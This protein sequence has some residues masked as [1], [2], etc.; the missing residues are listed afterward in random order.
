MNLKGSLPLLILHILSAG[1]SHGYHI[2]KQIRE[3]SDG[4]LD[5]KEGT[6][7]PTLHNL[8]DRGLIAGFDDVIDGRRRRYYQLT[9]VGTA[10]L[11]SERAEW[12]NFVCYVNKI[13]NEKPDPA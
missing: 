10:G 2:S 6:L 4:V 9:D 7:Y 12:D 8:E 3:K 11:S 5:F 1:P 13:L